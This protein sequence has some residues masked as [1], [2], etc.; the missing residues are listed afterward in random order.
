METRKQVLQLS[1]TGRCTK[2]Y[3]D[4]LRHLREDWWLGKAEHDRE[5]KPGGRHTALTSKIHLHLLS[6]TRP[7]PLTIQTAHIFFC[8]ASQMRVEIETL[9]Q[10]P[11]KSSCGAI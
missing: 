2:I 10:C 7:D 3:L 8:F 5:S 6:P 1:L 4:A 9:R 11:L